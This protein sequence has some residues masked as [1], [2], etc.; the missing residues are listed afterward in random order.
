AEAA[1]ADLRALIPDMERVKGKDHPDTL[2][3]RATIARA[4]LDQGKAEAAEADLRSLLPATERVMGKDHPH[5]LTTRWVA[6]QA[7][8][9][10][11]KAPAA[12]GI[13]PAGPASA[14]PKD[15]GRAALLRGWCADLEGDAAAADRDLAEAAAA[16]APLLP[17]HYLRRE[18]ARYLATR[19]PGQAGGSTNGMA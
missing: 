6:A 18:L 19:R 14:A 17:E 15:C 11:G 1:E 2:T 10:Q 16:L 9:A 3:T 12:R 5:T 7:A 13:M 8:L 4:L